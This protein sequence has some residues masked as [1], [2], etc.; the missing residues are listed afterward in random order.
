MPKKEEAGET[1]CSRVNEWITFDVTLVKK[2]DGTLVHRI[3][4]CDIN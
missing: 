2:V 4:L 3:S 1:M